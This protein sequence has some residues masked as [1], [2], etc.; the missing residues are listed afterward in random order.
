M[1][2]ALRSVDNRA[3]DTRYYARYW[4]VKIMSRIGYKYG[5]SRY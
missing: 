3:G 5:L 2:A 4:M 1:S